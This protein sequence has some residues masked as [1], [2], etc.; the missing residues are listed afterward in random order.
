[1]NRNSGS[2]C[3]CVVWLF[4]C[5]AACAPRC[6]GAE[7]RVSV[8]QITHGPKHHFYGYIGHV[9]NTPFSGSGRYLVALETEFQD[10]LPDGSEPAS[11]VLLDADDDFSVRKVNETRAWNLQQ[12]TMLYWNPAAPDREF[13]FNDRDLET[14][15]V[16]TVLFDVETG[17][18]VREYRHAPVSFGNA[19]VCPAGGFFLGINYGRLA[20]LRPVTGYAGA[21][22]ATEGV[23]APQ[24]DGVFQ[25]DV[26]TGAT[27]VLVSFQALADLL[28]PQRA[29]IDRVSLFIN[30]TLS[31]RDGEYVYFFVRGNFGRPDRVNVPCSVRA[32]G[33]ELTIHEQ[34][35]GGHPEWDRGHQLIGRE[36]PKQIL[37]DVATRKV[38]GQIGTPEMFPDPEGDIAISPD[39]RRFV[40]GYRVGSANYY[41]ILDRETGDFARSEGFEHGRWRRGALRLDAAP[42][43]RRDG[44]A[45]VVTGIASD[46][47]RQMF[48][49]EIE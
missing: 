30:H 38:V 1:M 35:I 7:L 32:D 5:A 28:R 15:D 39:G 47:T 41:A 29:N 40:N 27:E 48:L 33:S 10:H 20:R 44:N 45:I 42:C 25:V 23:A 16:F 14:G 43:W 9:M 6:G 24:N 46:G 22:D 8:R 11:I 18:R 4:A 2:L 31:S 21:A 37:Y 19:G 3:A 13:F 17:E 36:G 12:G 26:A 34:H 49:L